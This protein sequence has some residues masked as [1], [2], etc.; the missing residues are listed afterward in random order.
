MSTDFP[1]VNKK[2]ISWMNKL[3]DK[4]DSKRIKRGINLYNQNDVLE[5][6]V[7]SDGFKANIKGSES[8]T[9]D[10]TVKYNHWKEFVNSM[11]QGKELPPATGLITFCTCPDDSTICKHVTAGILE[12]LSSMDLQPHTFKDQS[13]LALLTKPSTIRK[14]EQ[15]AIRRKKQQ[16]QW[17]NPTF[18]KA[19][20]PLSRLL[21]DIYKTVSHTMKENND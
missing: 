9:Y 17:E 6:T 14:L 15:E 5:I 20:P 16:R 11:V 19:Y 18:W 7:E 8:N 1:F 2:L 21:D 4:A 10:V 3:F 12:W 13:Q